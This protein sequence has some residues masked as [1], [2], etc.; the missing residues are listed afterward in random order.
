M[1]ILSMI[2]VLNVLEPRVRMLWSLVNMVTEECKYVLWYLIHAFTIKQ[3]C[4]K[5]SMFSKELTTPPFLKLYYLVLD[6]L[7]K[8]PK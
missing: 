8:E 1:R 3:I 6:E 2:Y 5:H 7:T 4:I